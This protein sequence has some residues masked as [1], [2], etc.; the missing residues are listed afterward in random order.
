V[1]QFEFI[2]RIVIQENAIL[3]ALLFERATA[4]NQVSI[5]RF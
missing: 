1:N 2:T 5:N 4:Q 3:S